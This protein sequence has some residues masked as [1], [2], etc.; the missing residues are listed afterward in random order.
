MNT[1][2]ITQNVNILADVN[3]LNSEDNR[4]EWLRIR[5]T[6]IG[7]SEIA[8]LFGKS[9]YASPLS[10]YMDK[11]SDEIKEE[12]NEFIEW[13]KTLEPI[14]RQKFPDKF[15]KY[16]GNNI[17]VEEFPLMMQSK[18]DPFMLA[19]IDGIVEPLQDCKFSL[20][21]GD[22]MWEEYFIPAGVTGGL[23]IKTGSGFTM[24]NWKE[25]SLPDHYFLQTQ[26]YMK[27][28]GLPYFF[29]A[30]LIDKTLLWRFVPRDEDII[31]IIKQRV[32]E[33]W[34]ENV[35]KK[36]P[37]AP[38]GVNADKGILES[39][40]P[41]GDTEST[42]NLNELEKNPDRLE[43]CKKIRDMQ[44]GYKEDAEI[45]KAA[46]ARMELAKQIM[47]AFMGTKENLFIDSKKVTYKEMGQ[48]E[49]VIPA[50]RKRVLRIW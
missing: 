6:G 34:S 45:K 48:A 36:I 47:A 24:K 4:E 17:T 26:H 32:N 16:T 13:G 23:E 15:K 42:I 9:N 12:D 5:K 10:V 40:Y 3:K 11:L 43:E 30:A 19:N 50:W 39:L 22:D 31:T 46:E 1:E 29:V 35:L 38:I 8:A 7:G 2:V 20:Q 21:V 44:R 49:K 25:N 18:S 14:I 41:I 37:P 27:V 33:F 28:T